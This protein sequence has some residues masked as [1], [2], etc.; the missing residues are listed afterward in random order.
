MTGGGIAIARV[1]DAPGPRPGR[2]VLVDRMWP[3]GLSKAQASL[4]EWCR[5]IAPTAALRR[6]YAHRPERF[7]EF[8]QRYLAE[9][10]DADHAEACAHLTTLARQDRLILL[11]AVRNLALSHASVLAE[12]LAGDRDAHRTGL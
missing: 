3:R 2:R 8:R 12:Q 6:W 10:E 4:D 5:D 11:T 9:L 1:Y 7:A